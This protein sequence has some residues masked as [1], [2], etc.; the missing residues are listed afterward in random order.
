MPFESEL[1]EPST[2]IN[3]AGIDIH[4]PAPEDLIILKAVANR[5]KDREDIRSIVRVDPNLDRSRVRYWVDQ[6]AELLETSDLWN[7]IEPLLDGELD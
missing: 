4:Q 3:M 1:Q 6:Y 5:A 7:K 2:Q